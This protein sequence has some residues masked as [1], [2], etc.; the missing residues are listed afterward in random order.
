MSDRPTLSGPRLDPASGGK[1]KQL[2]I[3]L[4]GVGSD[5]NDL[6]GLAPHFAQVLPDALFAS[7]DAPYA[8]DMA[9]VGYQWFSL[10]DT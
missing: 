6:I 4:H 3:L 8:F 2:V 1:P 5:G 7:P 9:P 10:L